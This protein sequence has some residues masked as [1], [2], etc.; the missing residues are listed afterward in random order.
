MANQSNILYLN[1]RNAKS[2]LKMI[3]ENN[4]TYNLLPLPRD[5][6]NLKEI[7][8][9]EFYPGNYY[10]AKLSKKLI[11]D[12]GI[13]SL[14]NLSLMGILEVPVL[15]LLHDNSIGNALVL[16][17]DIEYGKI[18][19]FWIQMENL[20]YLD[21]QSKLS[22]SGFSHNQII[23]NFNE[24][25]KTLRIF[26]SKNILA[27]I[28]NNYISHTKSADVEE[29]ISYIQLATWRNYKS[30][31]ITGVFRNFKNFIQ[32]K[33]TDDEL[34]VSQ[35]SHRDH[36]LDINE[37][38]NQISLKTNLSE[39]LANK[40]ASHIEEVEEILSFILNKNE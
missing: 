10:L 4:Q 14:S 33:K 18:C 29:I 39:N 21:F 36:Y 13:K 16:Y 17:N 24:I 3:F 2:D 11:R 30:S 6:Y 8:K 19:T 28:L 7:S 38:F 1:N 22:P 31:P 34:I 15:L 40:H 32:V 23:D 5:S 35:E 27:K 37:I 9:E 26:Y 25:D 20:T 12:T